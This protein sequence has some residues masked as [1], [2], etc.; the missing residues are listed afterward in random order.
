MVQQY[1]TVRK[2]NRALQGDISSLRSEVERLRKA[3]D[4]EV[5]LKRAFMPYQEEAVNLRAEVERLTQE[6]DALIR[7]LELERARAELAEAIVCVLDK[8]SGSL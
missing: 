7:R 3:L 4:W 2:E 5:A 1:N 8:P 6:R